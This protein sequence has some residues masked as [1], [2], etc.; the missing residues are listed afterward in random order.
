MIVKHHKLKHINP[1]DTF[2]L[3]TVAGISSDSN[4]DR[5][6]LEGRSNRGQGVCV[7][8]SPLPL[9][10]QYYPTARGLFRRVFWEK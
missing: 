7:P 4:T 10:W 2:G 8:P 3:D 5:P 9:F 6:H 1:V